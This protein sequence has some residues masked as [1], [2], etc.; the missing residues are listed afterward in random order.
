MAVAAFDDRRDRPKSPLAH[1]LVVEGIAGQFEKS[2]RLPERRDIDRR[3][4]LEI[5]KHDGVDLRR[6]PPSM[7]AFGGDSDMRDIALA[8]GG[9]DRTDVCA[10]LEG[11]DHRDRYVLEWDRTCEGEDRRAIELHN[12]EFVGQE[13]PTA[14]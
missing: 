3:A 13:T 5:G 12:A 8:R 1:H 11:A 9:K 14:T 2:R 10:G 4:G 6:L 7:H